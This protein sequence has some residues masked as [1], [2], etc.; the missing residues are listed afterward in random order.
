MR[1]D[2]GQI[3]AARNG[4]APEEIRRDRPDGGEKREQ[5]GERD[6]LRYAAAT[7]GSA[8]ASGVGAHSHGPLYG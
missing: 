8:S 5:E 6:A 3:E 7:S 4:R 2:L 1:V